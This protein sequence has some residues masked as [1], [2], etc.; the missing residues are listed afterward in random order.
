MRVLVALSVVAVLICGV[1]YADEALSPEAQALKAKYDAKIKALQEEFAAELAAVNARVDALEKPAPAAKKWYDKAMISG[2]FQARFHTRNWDS[3]PSERDEFELRRLYI[4][5]ISPFD[6]KTT[7]VVTWAGV[8]PT[9]REGASGTYENIFVDYKPQQNWNIR[10]GQAPNCFGLD[11]AESS[12]VR[13]PPERALV[14]E[15]IPGVAGG[16]YAF[17]PSDRGVWVSWDGRP[18]S[19]NKKTGLRATASVHNG[20]FQDTDKNNDKNVSVDVD[21]FTDW[22]R[23]GAGWLD[24]EYTRTV[25]DAPVTQPRRAVGVNFRV[26]PNTLVE[27]MGFQGEY[28]DGEWLGAETDGWYVQGSYHFDNH[29]GTAYLRFEQFDPNTA[30]ANNDFEILHL[31]YIYNVTPVDKITVEYGYGEQGDADLDD[32]IVQYQRSL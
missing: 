15:G 12:S 28:I 4:N 19:N 8:G 5:L 31:G 21:Y 29:P 25:N 23:F 32:L 26:D 13:M 9:F 17:G 1:T 24:G 2:Y 11:A 14:T 16:L 3:Q 7:G 10:V 18:S 30:V 27:K 22:G 6:K 20:Q